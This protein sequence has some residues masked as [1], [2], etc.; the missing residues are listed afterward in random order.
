MRKAYRF[1]ASVGFFGS[2]HPWPL[3]RMD[4]CRPVQ[5]DLRNAS[6][7]APPASGD[8]SSSRT[9]VFGM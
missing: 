7:T 3:L 6:R 1:I 2:R 4:F 5:H 9:G 8:D